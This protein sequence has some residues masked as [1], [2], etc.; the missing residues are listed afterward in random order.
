MHRVNTASVPSCFPRA[1]LVFYLPDL[2]FS[3][4]LAAGMRFLYVYI[5]YRNSSRLF[6]IYLT[7]QTCHKNN[8]FVKQPRQHMGGMLG[9]SYASHSNDIHCCSLLQ[10]SINVFTGNTDLFLV[11]KITENVR[12]C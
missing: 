4:G 7:W 8:K 3:L 1:L 9:H 11:P 6:R 5:R 10:N 12:C 2:A